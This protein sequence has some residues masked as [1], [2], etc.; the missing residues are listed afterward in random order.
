MKIAI[1][2]AG[3]VGA[4]LGLGW[5]HAGHEV[6]FGLRDASKP[7][8]QALLTQAGPHVHATTPAMAAAGA[9]VV[10]IA[11]PFGAS[12][13]AV[14]GLGD[15]AGKILIDCT[16]PVGPDITWAPPPEGSSAQAIAAAAPGARVVKAFSTTGAE[17]M[18]Q[19]R[20]GDAIAA[21]FLAG[22]DAQAKAVVVGLSRDLGMEPV[23]TG[24]LARAQQLESLA[25]LWISL[26]YQQG[27]GRDFAFALARRT[28]VSAG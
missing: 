22:D 25:I 6:V 17:N 15:L 14:R 2:G 11:V 1:I 23:D 10:V 13:E 27:L 26:A 16:N 4:T 24:G 8:Y 3:N 12:L 28:P 7:A 5:A 9:E 18:R 19:P 20:L 21:N